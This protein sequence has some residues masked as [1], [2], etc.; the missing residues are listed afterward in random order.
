MEGVYFKDRRAEGGMKMAYFTP[1]VL[2]ILKEKTFPLAVCG[3]LHYVRQRYGA[4]ISPETHKQLNLDFGVVCGQARDLLASHTDVYMVLNTAVSKLHM[5]TYTDVKR[6]I[7]DLDRIYLN[8]HF[9]SLRIDLQCVQQRSLWVKM[10]FV[11]NGIPREGYQE[12]V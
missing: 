5:L 2:E 3:V 8:I 11:V 10:L 4:I 6:L 1:D 12:N 9:D 7:E